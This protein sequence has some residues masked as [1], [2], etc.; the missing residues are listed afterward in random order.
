MSASRSE[1]E[2]VNNKISERKFKYLNL[3]R[4][5]KKSWKIELK[6]KL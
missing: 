4:E 1:L 2:I 3:A 6:K 5:L